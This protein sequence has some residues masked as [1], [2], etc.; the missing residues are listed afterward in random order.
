MELI[1]YD[2][3]T[4]LQKFLQWLIIFVTYSN[5]ALNSLMRSYR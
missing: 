1:H 2:Q 5:H 3:M 4:M